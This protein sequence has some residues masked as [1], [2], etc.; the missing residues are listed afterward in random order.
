[1]HWLIVVVS[2]RKEKLRVTIFQQILDLAIRIQIDLE[3]V[4]SC[5]LH[6]YLKT[7]VG[8]DAFQKILSIATQI[9]RKS[10]TIHVLIGA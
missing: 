9:Y 8:W 3:H 1:M 5:K 4:S 10:Y 6:S 7:P 2:R